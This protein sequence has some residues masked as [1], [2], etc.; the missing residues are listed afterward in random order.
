MEL[1]IADLSPVP[2]GGTVA[3]A[4]ASTVALA[5][6]AELLGYRRYWVAEHH[7]M[8]HAVAGSSPEVL[9]ARLAAA[10][11]RM[12][13]GSGGVLL[14]YAA[15][16]RV[17]E[18]FTV[19]ASLFPGRIDLG[20]G[21]ADALPPVH[22]ALSATP[23]VNPPLTAGNGFGPGLAPG[24]PFAGLMGAFAHEDRITELL[25]W[26]AAAAAAGSGSGP[27]GGAGP[28]PA[29]THAGTGAGTAPGGPGTGPTAAT[30]SGPAGGGAGGAGSG[31]G[32]AG[33]GIGSGAGGDGP[34]PAGAGTGGAGTGAQ[35]LSGSTGLLPPGVCVGSLE[36]AAA[37]E[38][39]L[40]GSSP[41]SALL[42]ARLGLRYCFA[43]FIDPAA[44]KVALDAYRMA[45]RP[46]PD[47]LGPEDPRSMLAV[48]LCCADT[49]GE[50]DRLRASVEAFYSEDQAPGSLRRPLLDPDAAVARLGGVPAP[51]DPDRGRWPRHLSGGPSRARNL[52]ERLVAETGVDEVMV[53]DLVAD[54]VDRRRSYEL[55]A[56]AMALVPARA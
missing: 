17:A 15:P 12:R 9:I 19:L 36:P 5:G 16:L 50:A 55:L 42:A 11:S 49:A 6:Q 51:T 29:V 32:G 39:W 30:R 13:I 27:L 43:A 2:P 14:N 35:P 26:S 10:T 28:G 56:G 3:S 46:R 4:L 41:T 52:L 40:L 44:A 48:H 33:S 8:G 1:S 47:G 20:I 45:F 25:G 23:E 37:A 24:A 31:S 22:Q 34:G 53:Q 54:P 18:A 21:R 38:P 7:G